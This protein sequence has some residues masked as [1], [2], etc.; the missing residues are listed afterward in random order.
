MAMPCLAI[1]GMIASRTLAR[2]AYLDL[3]YGLLAFL[4]GSST[5]A[6]AATSAALN[7]LIVSLIRMSAPF[8]VDVVV[9]AGGQVGRPEAPLPHFLLVGE[10]D[11][12]VDDA[13]VDPVERG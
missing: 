13:D 3:R 11:E 12:A 6:C 5:S 9:G 4:L 7:S 2:L 1:T 10:P 8:D